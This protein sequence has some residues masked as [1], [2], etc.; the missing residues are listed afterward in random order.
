[1]ASESVFVTAV[2]KVCCRVEFT[3][4]SFSALVF[5]VIALGF[6]SFSLKFTES[7]WEIE[8]FL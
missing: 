1:M 8:V 4:D 5:L 6:S 7:K 2:S 3:S